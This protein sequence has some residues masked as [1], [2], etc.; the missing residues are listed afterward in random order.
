MSLELTINEERRVVDVDGST[1]LLWVI[2]DT[3]GLTGKIQLISIAKRLEE[4]YYPNDELP[5][6]INKRSST[7][8]VLQH[9]LAL[10]HRRQSP[11]V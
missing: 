1:P 9:L 7:L 8:R 3:L 5:Y 4:L 6:S 2:R 11:G 10:H